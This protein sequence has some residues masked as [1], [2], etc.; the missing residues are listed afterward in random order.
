MAAP[1]PLEVG[2]WRMS[3][4]LAP[5]LDSDVVVDAALR[6]IAERAPGLEA[7]A[8]GRLGRLTPDRWAIE[9]NLPAWLGRRFELDPRFVEALT[10]SN[11]LGLLSIR[12]Q[13][14]L[15]DGEVPTLEVPATHE[16]AGLAFDAA[17]AEYRAWFDDTSP[18]WAFIDRSI[19]EW[20]AGADSVDLAARG[21]PIRIAGYACCLQAG[22]LDVW[23][24]LQRSLD[25][26]VTALVRYDQLCDWESDL[27]AGRWNAF[28]AGVAGA[29]HSPGRRDRNRAAVL[30]AM[31]TR[32]LVRQEFDSAVRSATEA[33]GLADDLGI[34][35]LAGFLGDW[36][37]RT[38]G[39]GMKVANHYE[40]AGDEAARL[41]L[42]T[43]MG[44][45]EP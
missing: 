39:Q 4:M 14:D 20:R 11:V 1:T 10:R 34:G 32:P 9:W 27:D 16:L 44:G 30:T 38:S 37:E 15:H 22:R 26:A 40:H 36:A 31:L 6:R 12:L 18:I 5:L 19:A 28:V 8:R 41:L 7:L 43:R 21:A 25:G 23:P 17:V 3:P 42:G 13:D 35:E 24:A 29:E 33:A 2:T 45:A